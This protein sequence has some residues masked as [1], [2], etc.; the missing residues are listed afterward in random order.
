MIMKICVIS[1]IHGLTVWKDI[2][3]KERENVDRFVFLGDYVDDKSGLTSP[4]EQLENLH[5]IQ[6]FK[7]EYTHVDLLIGNHDLQYIGGARC[8]RFNSRLFDLVQ[9]ELMN[10]IRKRTLQ[11]CA[12]YDNYL[13]SHAGISNIWMKEKGME[14]FTDINKQFHTNPLILD[15]VNKINSD[16]SGNNVYQSPIWIRP[17]SLGKSAFPN[18]HH[19]VGHTR[20]REIGIVELENRKLIFTDTQ[21]RQYLIIDTCIEKEQIIKS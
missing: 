4:E 3:A 9:D 18:Y 17:D 2:V 8:N 20:I 14:D 19:V 12:C 11:A 5:S 13:F 7:E 16:G 10:M 6:D 15:F 1:D 21:L